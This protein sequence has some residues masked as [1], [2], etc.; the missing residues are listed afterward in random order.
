MPYRSDQPAD[1]KTEHYAGKSEPAQPMI[2]N[3]YDRKADAHCD[4]DPD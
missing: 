2:N 1:R 3:D 4:T